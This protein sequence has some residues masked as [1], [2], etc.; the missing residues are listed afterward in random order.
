MDKSSLGQSGDE[1]ITHPIKV[2]IMNFDIRLN[3]IIYVVKNYYIQ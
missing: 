1:K 2:A 3:I